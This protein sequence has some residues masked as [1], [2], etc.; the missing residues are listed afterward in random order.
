MTNPKLKSNEEVELGYRL[1]LEGYK[2]KKLA[3]VSVVHYRDEKDAFKIMI[4]KW[5]S[6]Y[7]KGAGQVLRYRIFSKDIFWH[8][9]KFKLYILM[10]LLW[11]STGAIAILSFFYPKSNAP[12]I[13]L[14][15]ISVYII[16]FIL[17]AIIRKSMIHAIYSIINWNLTAAGIILGFITTK[18]RNKMNVDTKSYKLIPN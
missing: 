10:I 4:D 6:G 13:L 2:L 11:I 7:L 5:R 14:T 16:G 18:N 12:S 9:N 15:L 17:L 3:I 8:I 1:R